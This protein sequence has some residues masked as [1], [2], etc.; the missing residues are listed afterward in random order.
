MVKEINAVGRVIRSSGANPNSHVHHVAVLLPVIGLLA[1]R[2]RDGGGLQAGHVWAHMT[3]VS[4][5]SGLNEGAGAHRAL[6]MVRFQGRW[7][8]QV[9]P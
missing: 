5:A 8:R 9:L 7:G 1:Q 2:A 6:A 4:P 3:K